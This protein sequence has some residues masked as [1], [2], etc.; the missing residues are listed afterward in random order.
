MRKK[1]LAMICCAALV[2]LACVH[3]AAASADFERDVIYNRQH[4]YYFDKEIDGKVA[5][6]SAWEFEFEVF[7]GATFTVDTE[8][9]D[10]L[11][12]G[13]NCDYDDVV[14]DR[15]SDATLVFFNGNGDYFHH[16]G[17]LFLPAGPDS[18]LYR[19]INRTLYD[20]GAIY[21]EEAGGFLLR[22]RNLA[23]Y[24]ISDKSLPVEKLT[25]DS[26]LLLEPLN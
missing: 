1:I 6:D 20:V 16:Y 14:L 3:V 10:D 13:A 12:L 5:E 24:V 7:D 21:D 8:G 11:T 17:T 26:P 25:P 9:Q 19:N 15:Y 2:A 23:Q 4:R 22:T 18:C